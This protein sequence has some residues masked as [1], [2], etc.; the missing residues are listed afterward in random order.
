MI[1]RILL[2]ITIL[3]GSLGVKASILEAS[4]SSE[5]VGPEL[6]Q[7][8]KFQ[9]LTLSDILALY[10]SEVGFV[11]IEED[12]Y[13]GNGA[14]VGFYEIKLKASNQEQEVKRT[15]N[16][17]VVEVLSSKIR[18]VTDFVNIHI[19]KTNKL[20][21][22][23]IAKIH[24][25]TGLFNINQ[26]SQYQILTDNYTANATVAG[27]YLFEYRV[28]DAT[29]FDRV[30]S[31]YI[32]VYDTERIE[33]PIIIQPERPNIWANLLKLLNAA[34]VVVVVLSVGYLMLKVVK[35]GR[36]ER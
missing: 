20:S 17:Q 4:A 26:T 6:I 8:E 15:I 32:T 7:K 11:L 33:N 22:T 16:V 23:E 5:I 2:T 12:N 3:I 31:S 10:S 35:K 29:G 36:K 1:K 24:S 30:I 27:K 18:A 14:T 21:V 25:N 9:V 34:L 13:T 19:S 28:M